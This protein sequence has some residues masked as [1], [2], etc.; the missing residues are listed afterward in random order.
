VLCVSCVCRYYYVGVACC[1]SAWL[2]PSLAQNSLADHT[3]IYMMILK[4]SSRRGANA[5]PSF[6]GPSSFVSSPET[7]ET[8]AMESQYYRG[9]FSHSLRVSTKKKTR[10]LL[11]AN[12][13]RHYLEWMMLLRT[14]QKH[15]RRKA[16]HSLVTF[17]TFLLSLPS[18]RRNA[19]FAPPSSPLTRWAEVRSGG[20]S[21]VVR[22][23]TLRV[24][25]R[26]TWSQLKRIRKRPPCTGARL[27]YARDSLG[28][29]GRS[30]KEYAVCMLMFCCGGF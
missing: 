27:T 24:L 21:S 6:F 10:Q 7:R 28:G 26:S 3:A 19:I 9:Q 25:G 12:K 29:C 5:F 1:C 4:P 11:V 23:N 14:I 15:I 16:V 13:P 17:L 20:C 8:H 18:R 2:S 22:Q 30:R